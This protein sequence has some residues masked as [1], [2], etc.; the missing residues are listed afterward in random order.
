MN[1]LKLHA[2]DDALSC[3]AAA[4]DEKPD[5]A[6]AAYGVGR[7]Y[8][9][10]RAF[11]HAKDAYERAIELWPT[12]VDAHIALGDAWADVRGDVTRAEGWYERAVGAN[13]GD[14][15]AWEALGAHRLSNGA[16]ASAL[17]TYERAISSV[18]GKN[19]GLLFGLARTRR[20]RG[21]WKAC[22]KASEEATDVAS[23][24]GQAYHLLAMCLVESGDLSDE[25]AREVE[26]YFRT[27]A[28]REP[29]FAAHHVD[30]AFF[31]YNASDGRRLGEAREVVAAGAKAEFDE[32]ERKAFATLAEA[33]E[34]FVASRERT[35]E[36]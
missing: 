5:F 20:A 19:A 24:F 16:L 28:T 10:K 33:F 2:N 6:P 14:A 23:E 11:E 9:E 21:E 4:L 25:R 13:E 26:G 12:Y 22:A 15:L 7:A 36:L 18:K 8:A 27:A 30:L 32:R 29:E 34:R 1:H 35:S 17:G 31:V 3:F